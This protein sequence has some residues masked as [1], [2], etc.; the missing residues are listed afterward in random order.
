[1][2]KYSKNYLP[3]IARL[4]LIST[5]L[6][7]GI[8]MWFQWSE[9]RDYIAYS[10]GCGWLGGT[11]FV[12]LNL[13][14][15]LGPCGFVLLRKHVTYAVYVLFAVVALQVSI[16]FITLTKSPMIITASQLFLNVFFFLNTCLFS[17]GKSIKLIFLRSIGKTYNLFKKHLL[18]LLSYLIPFDPISK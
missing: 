4:C 2:L 13:L 7:D 1:V 12:V 14:G 18:H 5:F 8:R 9:Q 15:Q 16:F 10:W 17:K 6:E 11:L 3:H